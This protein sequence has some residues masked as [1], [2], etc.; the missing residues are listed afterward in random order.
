MAPLW[1][2]VAMGIGGTVAM[3]VWA[4]VAAGLGI[5]GAPNWAMP[6]RWLAHV[7]RGRVFHDD[8]AAADPVGGELR[9]GWVFHYAVGILYGVIFAL[10]AGAEWLATP[11][12]VPVWIFA[13]VTILA[14]WMLLLP[15]MGLGWFAAKTPAPWKTRALGLVAHT[16][17]GL[18]MFGVAVAL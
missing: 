10:W 16:I 14:G 11:T 18:G 6:G 2:G 15:G 5:S 12:F 8:I 7:F 4:R 3:D 1:I 13:L 9:L 17:F